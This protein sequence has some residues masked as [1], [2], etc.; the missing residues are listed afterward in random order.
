MASAPSGSGSAGG[1]GGAAG[2]AL[3]IIGALVELYGTIEQGRIA[4]IQAG[5]EKLY[6]DL[7]LWNAEREGEIAVA[8]S[9]RTALEERRQADL[10]ASRA[11]AV[12][13]SSGGGVSDPTVV[14]LL[15]RTQGEGHYR[16]RVALYEG[17]ARSRAM[18]MSALSGGIGFDASNMLKAGY[19]SVA[20]GR[21]FRAGASL[22]EK[23]GMNGP[24][25][26]PQRTGGS[27]DSSLID[28]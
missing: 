11:L 2:A 8:A 15:S 28:E 9:Q 24:G 3:P 21:A 6:R 26:S 5:R 18:R 19:Q 7:A 23:Y 1:S 13:A 22:Y 12:A 10:A 16:A 17:E 20:L 4:R 27:G 25:S 14:E